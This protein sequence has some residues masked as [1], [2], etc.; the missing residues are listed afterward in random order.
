MSAIRG[1]NEV[2]GAAGPSEITGRTILRTGRRYPGS[3]HRAGLP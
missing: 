3:L 1:R 2:G